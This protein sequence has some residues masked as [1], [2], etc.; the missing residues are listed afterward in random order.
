MLDAFFG[1]AKLR[2]R[3]FFQCRGDSNIT[4]FVDGASAQPYEQCKLIRSSLNANKNKS[5][6][7][8][9]SEPNRQAKAVMG[10]PVV[11]K[12]TQ[13]VRDEK[14]RRILL[15]ELSSEKGALESAVAS[16]VQQEVAI[17]Q[18]NILLLQK[19]IAG[20]R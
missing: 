8:L 15:S 20:I 19:E 3:I 14:R 12:N 13:S 4:V 11:D 16:R 5:E 1:S 10:F 9:L 2:M 7:H 17:H 18:N 6:T